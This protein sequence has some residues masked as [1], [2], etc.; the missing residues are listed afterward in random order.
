MHKPSPVQFDL[1]QL[2]TV[3]P[4]I[5]WPSARLIASVIDYL[6]HA[7]LQCR[8][9]LSCLCWLITPRWILTGLTYQVKSIHYIFIL[10][11]SFFKKSNYSGLQ[12]YLMQDPKPPY[13]CK[14]LKGHQEISGSQW[15]FRFIIRFKRKLSL[16]KL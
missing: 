10:D 6:V 3:A 11:I 1:H 2:A 8:G 15:C 16:A 13:W 7:G 9:R 12:N 14:N 5:D 4:A